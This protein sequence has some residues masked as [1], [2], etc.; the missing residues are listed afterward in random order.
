M[1]KPFNDQR[2]LPEAGHGKLGVTQSQTKR[3]VQYYKKRFLYNYMYACFYVMIN[4]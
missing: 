1:S 4:Y 2:M 3:I